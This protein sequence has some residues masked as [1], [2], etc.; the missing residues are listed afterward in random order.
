M[1]EI[2]PLLKQ[3]G[4]VI[5]FLSLLILIELLLWN[6]KE[7]WSTIEHVLLEPIRVSDSQGFSRFQATWDGVRH[8]KL[9]IATGMMSMSNFFF[10][11]NPQNLFV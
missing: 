9:L 7:R 6:R 1:Y 8:N 4:I 3:A 5:H 11:Y 2:F 10:K